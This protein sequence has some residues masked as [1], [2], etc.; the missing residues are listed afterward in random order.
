[1]RVAPR[2]LLQRSAAMNHAQPFV[3]EC[4]P[5]IIDLIDVIG[6]AAWS[7]RS[8]GERFRRARESLDIMKRFAATAASLQMIVKGRLLRRLQLAGARRIDARQCCST[9]HR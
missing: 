4:N 7:R 5:D 1:M 2:E 9:S 6:F 8:D 3:G